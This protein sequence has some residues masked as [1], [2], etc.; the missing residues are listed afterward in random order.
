M[1]SLRRYQTHLL[2]I[3]GATVSA[4]WGLRQGLP[5]G[6]ALSLL[7]VAIAL[8]LGQLLLEWA[9]LTAR[10]Q[11]LKQWCRV[12]CWTDLFFQ[13]QQ[14]Y[15]FPPHAVLPLPVPESA[16]PQAT[17]I[18]RSWRTLQKYGTN[19]VSAVILLS[20]AVVGLEMVVSLVVYWAL[21]LGGLILRV[22]Q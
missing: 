19:L 13:D 11:R 7:L 4:A 9:S 21:H 1:R 20:L 18:E 5:P 14:F 15:A 8:L 22:L 10:T 3:L 17:R 2:L 6:Q 12:H 16:S